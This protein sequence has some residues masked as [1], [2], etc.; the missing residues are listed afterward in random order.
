M[1]VIPFGYRSQVSIKE[2]P[3]MIFVIYEQINQGT[4]ISV[5][6]RPRIES[7]KRHSK[8]ANRNQRETT[9]EGC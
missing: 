9:L 5:P 2:N 7:Q 6:P 4:H 8:K 1:F 3:R